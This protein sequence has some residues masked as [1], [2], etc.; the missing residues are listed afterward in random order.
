MGQGDAPERTRRAL[1]AA[2]DPVFYRTVYDD[3][4]RTGSDP[5]RHYAGTGWREGRD[6]A[7]WF[8]NTGYLERYPEAAGEDPFLHYLQVGWRKGFEPSASAH[9]DRFLERAGARPKAS[10]ITGPS[11][12]VDADLPAGLT[13]QAAR[14]L[15]AEAFDPV[16][17]LSS[18]P[19]VAAA[20][21]DPLE[22]F[23]EAGWREG[24]DPSPDFCGAEY[25]EANPDLAATGV[26]PL[27]HWLVA[28]RAEGRPLRFELGFRGRIVAGLAPLSER[29]DAAAAAAAAFPVS[30][31]R[32]LSP[33][34]GAS[35]GGGLHL[36]FSHDDYTARVGGVQLCLQTE[37]AGL[38]GRGV[39]HLHVFPVAPWPTLR[40]PGSRAPLGVVWNGRTL[41]GFAAADLVR[42]VKARAARAGGPVT[43]AIHSL[44]GHEVG[45][46]LDLLAAAGARR[47]FFWMHDFAGLCA[48]YHLMRDE[49]RDC[50]APPAGSAACR[51]CV[52]GPGRDL[53]LTG[54]RRLFEALEL[55][56]V[57]PSQAALDTWNAAPDAPQA[58][59]QV[60]HPHARLAPT[61]RRAGGDPDA[62]LTVAFL[63]MPSAYKGWPV[64]TDLAHRFR[65]DPRYRFVRLGSAAAPG[66]PADH[67]D[68]SVTADRPH[69][70]REALE[71]ARVDVAILWSL[72]R[73]T[74]S[75][76]AY[77][78]AAAGAA[79][80]TGPDSGNVAAFTRAG[81]HGLVLPD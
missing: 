68:V 3:I 5:L 1:A 49:A 43:F 23:L 56:L 21:V 59:R 38:A 71:A 17:Y 65:D 24:R 44:L 61:G 36:T 11:V 70:M 28:G 48:G 47:G 53:H 54:H 62:P 75:F 2:F 29:M 58:Q 6:P 66:A 12:P 41:G 81:G 13:R 64:F 52:F 27:L 50:G 55:T 34:S 22:H 45:E 30:R 60:V 7:S 77:E 25:L 40:P 76:A 74:F 14:Q 33:L 18:W 8:S 9:R 31:A 79:I 57:A 46:T 26:N 20:G 73:E 80:L 10:G 67:I 63:G 72:C 15:A 39:D 16:F 37:A 51:I 78:A 35:R 4:G 32:A 69:A 19:D 42:A